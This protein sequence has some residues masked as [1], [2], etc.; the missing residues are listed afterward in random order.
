MVNDRALQAKGCCAPSRSYGSVVGPRIGVT[1][2]SGRAIDSSDRIEIPG[3]RALI[4]TN[5]QVIAVDGEGPLRQKRVSPFRIDAATV[6]NKRFS[7]FVAATGYQT[8]AERLGDSLVFVGLLP[9]DS[10]PSRAVAAVPW[11]WQVEGACWYCPVG[12]N[13]NEQLQ[14]D[15]PVTHV[16]WNDASA[17]AHWAGGQLPSEAEWEH[18]AR[19]KLGDV[20]YPWGDR[21]PDDTEF[22]PCNIWQ[23]R[24]PGN[25]TGA[26]GHIGPAPAKS[27]EPNDYGLYNMVGNVWEWTSEPFRVRSLKKSV[28]AQHHGK[29]G[30]KLSKGGSFLCH[31]SYCFRYRIAARTGTSPDTTS[32]HQGFRLVYPS[33]ANR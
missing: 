11:W 30:F 29:K 13:G 3:A 21:D 20:R 19:G 5:A 31:V 23:G 25:N 24:F 16:S 1:F 32:S 17:F 10:P 6:T 26:D 15:D 9:V 22:L 12:P 7:A 14:Q 4:G 18:A 28:A 33:K 27:F 2:G 8:E